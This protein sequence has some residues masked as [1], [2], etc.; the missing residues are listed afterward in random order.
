MVSYTQEHILDMPIVPN[1]Q[2]SLHIQRPAKD[3]SRI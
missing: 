1:M 3:D 2:V